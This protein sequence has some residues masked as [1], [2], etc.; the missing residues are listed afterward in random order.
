MF[1]E[2]FSEQRTKKNQAE[3][4]LCLGQFPQVPCRKRQHAKSHKEKLAGCFGVFEYGW[5]HLSTPIH[6]NLLSQKKKVTLR[7][8]RYSSVRLT[9][10]VI[11]R[12]AVKHLP[13]FSTDFNKR[14]QRC[15]E[16]GLRFPCC[17]SPSPGPEFRAPGSTRAQKGWTLALCRPGGNGRWHCAPAGAPFRYLPLSPP[18]FAPALWVAPRGPAR[19]LAARF[20][21]ASQ[22]RAASPGC[23]NLLCICIGT[24]QE[25]GDGFLAPLYG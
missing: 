14:K 8:R 24:P 16:E 21:G 7:P 3:G 23:G 18:S 9:V 1:S 25:H 15:V 22:A 2:A 10:M 17:R 12:N 11:N 5:P 20:G 6:G 4:L 13:V 19:A